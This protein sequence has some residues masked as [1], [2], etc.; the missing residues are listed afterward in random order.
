M[1]KVGDIVV[2]LEDNLDYAVVKNGDVLKIID[3]DIVND[4]IHTNDP[5]LTANHWLFISLNKL[6]LYNYTKHG[7]VYVL[8]DGIATVKPNN[9]P[10]QL[11]KTVDI[12]GNFNFP[13]NNGTRPVIL[14]AGGATTSTTTGVPTTGTTGSGGYLTAT[15]NFEATLSWQPQNPTYN[16]KIGDYVNYAGQKK[17]IMSIYE[18]QILLKCGASI[19]ILCA[20]PWTEPTYNWSQIDDEYQTK[21]MVD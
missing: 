2:V 21:Y 15:G 4:I 7:P 1:F 6:E 12:T 11:Y 13:P 8:Q 18:N 14:G 9:Y 20:T 10:P 19:N 17:R 16:W 5:S 3:V